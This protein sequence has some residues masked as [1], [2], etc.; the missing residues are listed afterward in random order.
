MM[1]TIVAEVAAVALSE[2]TPDGQGA[3]LESWGAAW[4]TSAVYMYQCCTNGPVPHIA[5]VVP[6]TSSLLPGKPMLYN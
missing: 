5:T 4:E 6:I 2:V 1:I 3:R